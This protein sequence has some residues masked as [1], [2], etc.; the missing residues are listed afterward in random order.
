MTTSFG[1]WSGFQE[2]D[3]IG[4][5]LEQFVDVPGVLEADDESIDGAQAEHVAQRSIFR[6]GVVNRP[7]PRTFMPTIPLPELCISSRTEATKMPERT[8]VADSTRPV[9]ML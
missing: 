5:S 6:S 4:G 1:D 7:S 2:R 8:A 9:A 3:R